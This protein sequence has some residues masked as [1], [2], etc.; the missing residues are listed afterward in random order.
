[1]AALN[2]YSYILASSFLG[3]ILV[4]VLWRWQRLP[5]SVPLRIIL[6]AVYIL[7]AVVFGRSRQYP[8]PTVRTLAEAEAILENEHPTFL[9]LY[10]NY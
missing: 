7:A 5:L 1:M 6:V 10:S 2:Q 9:M 3:L 4:M 8:D